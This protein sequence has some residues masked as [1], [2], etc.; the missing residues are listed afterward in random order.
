M[1][2]SGEEEAESEE[3]RTGCRN[4]SGSRFGLVQDIEGPRNTF[5][6]QRNS[7]RNFH[8]LPVR[9]CLLGFSSSFEE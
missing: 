2:V 6:L 1:V 9:L 8:T 5:I 4:V 7:S 3:D